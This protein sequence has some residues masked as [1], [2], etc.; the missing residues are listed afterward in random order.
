MFRK[1][2]F[3]APVALGPFSNFLEQ[4]SLPEVLSH[5]LP[6]NASLENSMYGTLLTRWQ[7][8]TGLGFV[9]VSTF[10]SCCY[11]Y[12]P[13][14]ATKQMIK[15][16]GWQGGRRVTLIGVRL[17]GPKCGFSPVKTGWIV[18]LSIQT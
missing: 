9:L 11:P 10:Q 18:V 2:I 16:G 7:W 14:V 3:C 17:D 6:P 4:L 1:S 13:M 15:P 12:F 8:G 5:L